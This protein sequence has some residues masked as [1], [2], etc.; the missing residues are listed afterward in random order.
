MLRWRGACR[1]KPVATLSLRARR[2]RPSSCRAASADR[3]EEGSVTIDTTEPESPGW[4][5]DRLF[6]RLG[7]RRGHYDA[8]DRYYVNENSIPV[9]ADKQVGQA[10]Q[11]LMAVSRTNFAELVVEAVRERMMPTGFRTGAAGDELGDSEAWAIWQA[12]S[13][14][15]DSALVHAASLSMGLGFVIVGP[16][17]EQ[18]ERPL[19]TPEDPR[20]VIV[21]TDPRR[22]RKVLAGLK[23]FRDDVAS[24]DRAFVYLP[25]AVWEAN[26]AVPAQSAD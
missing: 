26:R 9:G 3:R 18:G 25:G 14:D 13:L 24:V 15:A 4:W 5:L 6:R 23:V 7:D 22:R 8:L 11:R 10:Y 20:E 1:G 2:R 19:I 17:P 21:E 12:N 16:P